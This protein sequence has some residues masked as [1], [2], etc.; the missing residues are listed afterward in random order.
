[1]TIRFDKKIEINNIE[2]I[3]N[4]TETFD[5]NIIYG[6]V[7]EE[8][9]IIDENT[10]NLSTNENTEVLENCISIIEDEIEEEIIS[11]NILIFDEIYFTQE[12]AIDKINNTIQSQK[13]IFKNCKEFQL[14]IILVKCIIKEDI[15]ILKKEIEAKNRFDIISNEIGIIK[16]LQYNIDEDIGYFTQE[17]NFMVEIL[18]RFKKQTSKSR[19]CDNCNSVLNKD[20]IETTFCPL[21]KSKTF[22][23][24]KTDVERAKVMKKKIINLQKEIKIITKKREDKS[25]LN[26]WEYLTII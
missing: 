24:T 2:T 26:E 21:C 17:S 12:E 14:P 18:N 23:T 4:E 6:K 7:I 5:E 9:E 11:E 22:L 19:T 1:M 13:E 3:I 15:N 10:E 25:N 20:Y 16:D 8:T